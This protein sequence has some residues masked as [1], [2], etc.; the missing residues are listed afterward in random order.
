[1]KSQ[2]AFLV[3]VSALVVFAAARLAAGAPAPAAILSTTAITTSLSPSVYGQPVTFVATVGGAGGPP[4]GTVQFKTNGANCG[5]AATLSATGTASSAAVSGLG[6]GANTVTAEY[7][8]DGR[9]SASRGTLA[10]GQKV[11]KA[12]TATAVASFKNPSADGEPVPF[13]V[14]GAATAPGAGTP[15][16]TVQLKTNS[17]NCGSA[18][19]LTAGQVLFAAVSGLGV[20]TNAVTAEY[21]GDGSFNASSRT[22][23]GG[24]KVN[25][26]PRGKAAGP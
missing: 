2:H 13:T 3:A 4:T 16:G 26:A 19:A 22:L 1:M 10:G 14:M 8:G 11:N 17:V 7:S 25:K 24:Q 20:G 18:A 21:S 5:N 9:F 12:D 15:T 6:A 23:T